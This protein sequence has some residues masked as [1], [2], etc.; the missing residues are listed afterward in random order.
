MGGVVGG[1]E[2]GVVGGGEGVGVLGP[3]PG[4]KYRGYLLD[5]NLS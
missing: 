1:G 3:F 5:L 4:C 2:G